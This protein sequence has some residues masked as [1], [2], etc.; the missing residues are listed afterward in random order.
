MY[1]AIGTQH[2]LPEQLTLIKHHGD[3]KL[4]GDKTN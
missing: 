4:E 2:N 1:K 3:K